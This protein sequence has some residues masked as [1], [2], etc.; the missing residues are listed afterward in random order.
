[1]EKTELKRQLAHKID[2]KMNVIRECTCSMTEYLI[3]LRSNID[4]VL[5]LE[6]LLNEQFKD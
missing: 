6:A 3:C 4:E 2:S 5:F 1:M